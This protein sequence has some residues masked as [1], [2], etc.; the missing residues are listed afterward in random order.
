VV[1]ALVGER[2]GTAVARGIDPQPRLP[3]PHEPGSDEIVG[4]VNP[5]V[6]MA[7]AGR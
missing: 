1:V 2:R 4:I 5:L 7:A 6:Q 3:G